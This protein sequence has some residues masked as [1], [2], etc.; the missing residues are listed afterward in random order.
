VRLQTL[1]LFRASKRLFLVGNLLAGQSVMPKI[2]RC[3]RQV[4][5]AKAILVMHFAKPVMQIAQG[6]RP[7]TGFANRSTDGWPRSPRNSIE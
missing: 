7:A 4:E 3:A 5:Y 1:T 6:S 2:A